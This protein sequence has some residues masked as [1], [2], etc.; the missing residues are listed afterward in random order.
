MPEGAVTRQQAVAD[1]QPHLG[2]AETFDVVL[3]GMHQ[4]VLDV[5][6]LHQQVHRDRPKPEANDVA[7]RAAGILGGQQAGKR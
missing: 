3:A 2:V 6:E 7:I 1:Q 5:L 4:H